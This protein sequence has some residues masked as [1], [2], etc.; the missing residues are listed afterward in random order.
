MYL[1]VTMTLLLLAVPTSALP[2]CA[3][4]PGQGGYSGVFPDFSSFF[5]GESEDVPFQEEVRAL[6]KS[7]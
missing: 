5:P 7:S 1:L 2:Y 6:W 4:S 3:G